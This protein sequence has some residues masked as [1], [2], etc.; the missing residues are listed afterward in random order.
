MKFLSWPADNKLKLC[1]HVNSSSALISHHTIA[2]NLVEGIGA[3][4]L[5]SQIVRI[6]PCCHPRSTLRFSFVWANR[7]NVYLWNWGDLLNGF[8]VLVSTRRANRKTICFSW[9]NWKPSENQRPNV[10]NISRV[11]QT[12]KLQRIYVCT[13]ACGLAGMYR[14]YIYSVHMYVGCTIYMCSLYIS[15]CH[16]LLLLLLLF[17]TSLPSLCIYIPM[18][19]LFMHARL[20][21]WFK[22][23]LLL[24][25]VQLLMCCSMHTVG[26]NWYDIL[27]SSQYINVIIE[28]ILQPDS[29]VITHP[30][31]NLHDVC[32]ITFTK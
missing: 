2:V 23:L 26:I 20:G 18:F 11:R 19:S 28:A 14:I 17:L 4:I 9:L 6:G 31:C 27:V 10:S 12:N 8:Y 15:I 24:L 30:V 21:Q 25:F 7:R 29:P 32:Q 16:V 13:Q 1:L 3:I 22:C 5:T